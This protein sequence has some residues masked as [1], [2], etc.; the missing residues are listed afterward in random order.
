VLGGREEFPEFPAQ[1]TLELLDPRLELHNPAI[2]RQQHLDYCHTPRV[3]DRLSLSAL[4][5][6]KNST[7]QS[8]AP[9][10]N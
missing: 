10:T 1:L 9:Q 8:Y 3:I 6:Y 7:R 5:A 4:H 2:H